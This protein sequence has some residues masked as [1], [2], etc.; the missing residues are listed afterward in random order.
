M[1]ASKK[2]SHF[3]G[4]VIGIIVVLLFVCITDWDFLKGEITNYS[5]AP[6]PECRTG[7]M[8]LNPTVYRPSSARQE[9]VSWMPGFQS[10]DRYTNCAVVDRENW[11]CTY[12]DNSGT[13]GFT[14]GKFWHDDEEMKKDGW[15]HVSRYRYLMIYWKNA[16]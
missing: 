4:W 9:V 5:I 3:L 12:D 14:G 13:I 7:M 10:V 11:Q 16:F 15:E 6:C 1:N 2:T 8:T